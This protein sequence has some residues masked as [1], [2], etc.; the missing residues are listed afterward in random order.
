MAQYGMIDKYT[1]YYG[2][3]VTDTQ[4]AE[5]EAAFEAALERLYLRFTSNG[6]ITHPT[7]SAS[8]PP[9]TIVNIGSG[10]VVTVD[11]DA[12]R[13]D[14]VQAVNVVTSI[15]GPYQG[16]TGA[17]L[18]AGESRWVVVGAKKAYTDEE[19]AVDK[20][21]N[22]VYYKQTATL[23]WQVWASVALT[24]GPDDWMGD[25]TL[26]ALLVLMRIAKVE[27]VCLACRRQGDAGAITD[28]N[29]FDVSTWAFVQ[30]SHPNEHL[31]GRQWSAYSAFPVVRTNDGLVA[32]AGVG[33]TD[34]T[35][36]GGESFW[37]G[38]KSARFSDVVR[39]HSSVIPATVI[40]TVGFGI[41]VWVARLYL[42]ETDAAP[43]IYTGD[44]TLPG[45]PRDPALAL[46]ATGPAAGVNGFPPT[47]VDIALCQFTT[48]VAD[49]ITAIVRIGNTARSWVT[50]TSFASDILYDNTIATNPLAAANVQD[51]LDELT[52]EKLS[53]DGSIAMTGG[54]DMGANNVTNVGTVD[55]RDV[56]VDGTLLDDHD[57]E[58]DNRC[59]PL[60]L[61]YST[62]NDDFHPL[63]RAGFLD[64]DWEGFRLWGTGGKR[65]KTSTTAAAATAN[66]HHQICAAINSGADIF[67]KNVTDD[68]IPANTE[69]V[70][71]R[72]D[73]DGTDILRYMDLA[74]WS[75]PR[76]VIGMD[77]H[78]D[79][80]AQ[81]LEITPGHFIKEGRIVPFPTTVTLDL[82]SLGNNK[83]TA[84]VL[85]SNIWYYVY[86]CPLAI[87]NT[88]GG[89]GSPVAGHNP[90]AHIF[91]S[92]VSPPDYTG[93]HPE[94]PYTQFLGAVYCVDHTTVEF[95]DM[96][97][98]SDF[99]TITQQSSA[100]IE[101]DTGDSP[102]LLTLAGIVPRTAQEALISLE[103][104]EQNG[105]PAS[106]SAGPRPWGALTTGFPWQYTLGALEYRLANNIRMPLSRLL[107]DPGFY[108]FSTVVGDGDVTV[109]A[110]VHGYYEDRLRPYHY[111]P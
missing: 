48:N 45:Y 111:E 12:L 64:V 31:D 27:P 41:G 11:G 95:R 79:S 101:P 93:G 90:S 67:L 2:L 25:A 91:L 70:L 103:M 53:I 102:L 1:W 13:W 10:S 99:V 34:L 40:S 30:N 76:E 61:V 77:M 26:T 100:T 60:R 39:Q 86:A 29:I 83:D 46:D 108:V 44:T 35:F 57:D 47:L 68:G 106:V 107:V 6:T 32:V 73:T 105:A 15:Y 65:T 92:L 24:A 109:A 72:F 8:G 85:A 33:T 36:T 96:T 38:W 3:V 21:G 16:L 56:S 62:V 4:F 58:A 22:T 94:W 17:G 63:R 104:E 19:A 7:C 50:T 9:D 81:E 82:T 28:S 71:A 78:L 49:Q 5:H 37:I 69:Q 55:G 14:S 84:W 20:Q 88:K 42:A 52:D 66:K 110:K 43:T 75:T 59:Y 18:A 74:H 98:C 87:Y 51:A 54:L 89:Q 23:E 80:V 97:K